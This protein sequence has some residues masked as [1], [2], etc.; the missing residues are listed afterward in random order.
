MINCFI[1]CDDYFETRLLRIVGGA[2]QS[3]M[4]SP[5]MYYFG[6]SGKYNNQLHSWLFVVVM[7]QIFFLF[8]SVQIFKLTRH[9]RAELTCMPTRYKRCRRRHCGEH[10]SSPNEDAELIM[11]LNMQMIVL[12]CNIFVAL[13]DE[14]SLLGRLLDS[15]KEKKRGKN[16]KQL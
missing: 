6:E 3:V 12:L 9:V 7:L 15:W 11:S 5:S 10:N 4:L 13:W 1:W 16:M 2:F 14:L 8:Q